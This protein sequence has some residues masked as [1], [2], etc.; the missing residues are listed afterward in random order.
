MKHNN[1]VYSL[2]CDWFASS[3]HFASMRDYI[4]YYFLFF[5]PI[6]IHYHFKIFIYYFIGEFW[7]E[8]ILAGREFWQYYLFQE[9]CLNFSRDFL[10]SNGISQR[11][12]LRTLRKSPRRIFILE[13]ILFWYFSLFLMLKLESREF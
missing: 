2:V 13:R 9:N 4:H 7:Q 11:C 3:Y 5:Y 6:E 1:V 8:G 10:E 12:F